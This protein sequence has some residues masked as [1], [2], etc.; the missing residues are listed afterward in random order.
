MRARWAAFLISVAIFLTLAV[1]LLVVPRAAPGEG[2]V[3]VYCAAGLRQ[4][5]EAIAR[6]YP[7][8][9]ELQF[10][11]SNTLLANAQVSRRGDLYIPADD[12]YVQKAQE[13]GLS[14][15]IFPLAFQAPMLAVARGNPKHIHSI[16]DL[17]RPDVRLAQANPDAAAIGNL[18]RRLLEKRGAWEAL[19]KKTLVFK[20]TVNDVAN[21]LKLGTAD[22]GFVWNATVFQYPELEGVEAAELKGERAEICAVVLKSSAVPV[23]TLRFAR[24]VAARDRGLPEFAKAGYEPAPGD[25][26][27]EKPSLLVYAG[28]MLRPA[29]EKTLEAFERREGCSITRVYNGCGILVSQMRSGARPDLYFSCDSTFME[30]VKDLFGAAVDVS[31]NQL[32]ILVPKGNPR[33]IRTLGDLAGPGLRVGVGHEKQC[34]LGVLTQETLRQSRVEADV[35]KNVVVQ[36][37]TGDLLVNQIRAGSLDAVIAYVSNGVSAADVLEAIPLDLPCAL[38]VQPAAVGKDSRR[39]GLAGRLLEALRSSES[40]EQFQNQGF[41]WKGAP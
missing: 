22:A 39:P 1:R 4:P 15:E 27:E 41:R 14:A 8:R 40:R 30:R 36:T 10:G 37:P 26:W 13:K 20:P 19:K 18:T 24:Y 21:D 25:P 38:S 16:S 7:G 34:A 6:A 23:S 11:G 2:P 33:H 9:V 32:V 29:I 12:S 35:M 3:L 28:A 5:L 31:T 17:L